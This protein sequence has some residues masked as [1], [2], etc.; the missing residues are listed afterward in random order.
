[1]ESAASF[2]FGQKPESKSQGSSDGNLGWHLL[3]FSAKHPKAL[4]MSAQ[5]HEEY[6][7][8][9]PDSLSNMA[10]TLNTKRV[11]H[12][13]RAFCVT[14]GLDSFEISKILKPALGSK[15]DLVFV[16]TGQG[17]QWAGMGLEL[18]RSD[19]IF[20]DTVD[21]LDA[22]LSRLSDGPNWNMRG[23]YRPS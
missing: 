14:D 21:Y 11:V 1:M 7:T 15:C 8:T 5:K 9:H 6:L 12:S 4:E 17:A 20:K 2:G 13:H 16:F 23:M 18:L 19:G 22:E 3:T 10:Y